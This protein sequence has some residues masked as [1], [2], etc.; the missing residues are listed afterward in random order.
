MYFN[1][2]NHRE[3]NN[4]YTKVNYQIKYPFVRVVKDGQQ[5]GIFDI[6][7]ARRM[8]FDSDMDLV[9]IAPNAKPPVCH[10]LKYDK[11]R[12]E[13]KLKEKENKRKQKEG[14][15]ETKEI[16]LTSAIEPHDVE[17]KISAV[18]KFLSQGKKVNLILEYK[19]REIMFKEKGFEVINKML[20]MLTEVCSVESPPKMEGRRLICRLQPKTEKV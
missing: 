15:I 16:R 17:T 6:E 5:L 1:K 19:K 14:F 4:N 9:E 2:N 12:Y 20:S 3:N 18:K 11:Y 8:A 13:Q 10:I 7:R